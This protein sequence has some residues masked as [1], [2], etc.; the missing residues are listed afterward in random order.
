MQFYDSVYGHVEVNEPL[1]LELIQSAPVQ[2]LKGVHQGG[3]HYLVIPKDTITR[4]EHSVGVML[5]LRRFGAS[6]EEQA[7]GLLHDAGHT[8]F[9]HVIDYV[10][11]EYGFNYDDAH[12]NQ[13]IQSSG[14]PKILERHGLDWKSACDKKRHSLLEQP[15]PLLCADRIDYTMRDSLV[16]LPHTPIKEWLNDLTVYN[17][18]FVFKEIQTAKSFA[19]HYL[20]LV[21]VL[22]GDALR[23]ASYE[24]LAGALKAALND[25]T[26]KESDFYGTDDAVMAALKKSNNPVIQRNLRLLTPNLKIKVDAND[27]D[28]F[29]PNKMRWVDPPVLNGKNAPIALSALDPEIGQAIRA[30]REKI[31]KGVYIRILNSSA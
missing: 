6:L 28:Y 7:A 22:Y 13:V 25:E 18:Q 10:F 17:G 27:Y 8:A 23:N 4:Y 20:K 19:L 3:A 24:L 30:C 2:R 12:L 16:T 5:L 21:E 9:S 11:E 15:I 29:V 26:L 1:L 31:S 14:I